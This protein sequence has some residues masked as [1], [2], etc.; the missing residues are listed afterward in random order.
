M[1]LSTIAIDYM[2]LKVIT[3]SELTFLSELLSIVLENLLFSVIFNKILW[4]FEFKLSCSS[5]DERSQWR[6]SSLLTS[7]LSSRA[8]SLPV[9]APC[10]LQ[11]RSVSSDHHS[12][13]L[14]AGRYNTQ[15]DMP[16][17]SSYLISFNIIIFQYLLRKTNLSIHSLPRG[18]K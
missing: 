15:S 12:H 1:S 18:K 16:G 2:L 5:G 6:L 4:I 8:W 11:F 13:H 7:L 9:C 17:L 14:P 3:R 10:S